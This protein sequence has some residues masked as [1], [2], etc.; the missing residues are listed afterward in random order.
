MKVFRGGTV[1]HLLDE[2][3]SPCRWE[4]SFCTESWVVLAPGI[5]IFL[6]F[7]PE[8][9]G[10]NCSFFKVM[11]LCQKYIYTHKNKMIDREVFF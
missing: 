3:E 5:M 6:S 8:W 2:L 10:T 9:V 11:D 7:I 1:I 4:R